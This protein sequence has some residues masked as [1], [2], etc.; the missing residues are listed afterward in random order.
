[1][2]NRESK[3][4]QKCALGKTDGL[5][6]AGTKRRGLHRASVLES[7]S[8]ARRPSWGKFATVESNFS[9]PS[10]MTEISV[11]FRKF[12]YASTVARSAKISEW[13]AGEEVLT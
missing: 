8:V 9:V 10:H 3:F 12:V 1:V 2:L 4:E 7:K 5:Q 11:R 6:R 13:P